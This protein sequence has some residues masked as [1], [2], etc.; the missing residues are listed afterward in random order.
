MDIVDMAIKLG[1]GGH[2]RQ[3]MSIFCK[4]IKVSCSFMR[5]IHNNHLLISIKLIIVEA[6]SNKSLENFKTNT[7]LL[8]K[9]FLKLVLSSGKPEF[10]QKTV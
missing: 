2:T 8:N 4:N 7:Y 3:K 5:Y 6:P 1:G 9:Q 10:Y